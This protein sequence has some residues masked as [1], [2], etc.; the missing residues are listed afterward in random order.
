MHHEHAMDASM[1][2]ESEAIT[3][4]M[5]MTVETSPEN[6]DLHVLFVHI[7]FPNHSKSGIILSRYILFFSFFLS[8][9]NFQMNYSLC[10]SLPLLILTRS[11][12]PHLTNPTHLLFPSNIIHGQ[13]RPHFIRST[14]IPFR[15][16]T[17]IPRNYP[18][19]KVEQNRRQPL[20]LYSF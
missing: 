1:M 8:F 17:V 12:T 15:P 19:W 14:P 6:V 3:I 16:I 7:Q 10:F 5:D 18:V 13:L 20:S 11:L 4:S 2:T 9:H